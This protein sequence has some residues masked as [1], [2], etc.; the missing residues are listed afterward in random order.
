MTDKLS[1]FETIKAIRQLSD[2]EWQAVQEKAEDLRRLDA[3]DRFCQE[4]CDKGSPQTAHLCSPDCAL[5]AHSPRV[6]VAPKRG[7]A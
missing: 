1:V 2:D 5:A 6:H 3:I 7:A 4:Q